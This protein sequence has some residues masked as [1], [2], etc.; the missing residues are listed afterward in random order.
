MSEERKLKEKRRRTNRDEQG[1]YGFAVIVI[2]GAVAVL[3]SM[4]V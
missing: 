4:I 3:L 2:G 1:F